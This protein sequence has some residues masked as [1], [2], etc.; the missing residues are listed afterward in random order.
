MW[1]HLQAL[2]RSQTLSEDE[3]RQQREQ[4]LEKTPVPVFW[5][6]G[7]TGSGKTSV[8]KFLTGA[9]RAEIGDGFRPQT[10]Y[11]Q[12]YIF[13]SPDQPLLCFIDTRGLAEARYDPSE[14]LATLDRQTHVL[15][16]TVRIM[17]HALAHVVEP[18]RRIRQAR[19]DRPVLLV[20]TCLHEAYPQQPHPAAE[21]FDSEVGI[22][23]LPR[24]LQASLEKQ[25]E[26]F[27]GLVDRIVA[28][29]LTEPADGFIEANYRGAALKDALLELLPGAYRQALFG[30]GDAM[31]SL[32]DLNERRAMPYILSYS[33]MAATAAAVPVPWVDIPVVLGIQSHLIYRLAAV[34]GQPM[35]AQLLGQMAGVVGGRLLTRLVLRET[36][37]LIPIAGVPANV[38]M[39]Y[40]YTYGLGKASCWYFAQIR[41]GH[42]PSEEDLARVWKA[43]LAAAASLWKER[44]SQETTP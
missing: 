8:V 10:R 6:F 2:W 17:D 13:P 41:G 14:D 32:H 25:R 29:D 15:V 44:P 42:V 38:A 1:R 23:Q 31:Q 18:L 5:L 7:K 11:S 27:S 3:Y 36:L 24:E 19:P 26:R 30:L 28:V 12:R 37:K 4:I 22:T 40:A 33:A 16:V 39:A 35:D 43:Q 34:Y 20:L 9:E 21:L